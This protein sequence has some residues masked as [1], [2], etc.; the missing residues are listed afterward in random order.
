MDKFEMNM[1]A[2]GKKLT[3]HSYDADHGFAN[4]SNAI[5]DE[6]AYQDSRSKT[7]AYFKSKF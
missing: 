7:I 6:D 1:K 3:I 4:P 5:F 2:A